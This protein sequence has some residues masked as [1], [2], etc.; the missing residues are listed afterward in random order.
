MNSKEIFEKIESS[1]TKALNKEDGIILGG[2]KLTF[3]RHENYVRKPFVADNN[4]IE[5]LVMQS[6]NSKVVWYVDI[7]NALYE[8][9]AVEYCVEELKKIFG[10]RTL[11]SHNLDFY[12]KNAFQ[13]AITFDEN[14]IKDS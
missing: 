8:Y 13:I 14:Q 7:Y 2:K 11:I 1:I 3:Y 12:V 4:F 10:E 9:S 5:V 6:D